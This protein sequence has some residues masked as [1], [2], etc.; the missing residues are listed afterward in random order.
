MHYNLILINRIGCTYILAHDQNHPDIDL[1]LAAGIKPDT[2][3]ISRDI[4]EQEEKE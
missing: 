3:W 2:Q 1:I 4:E